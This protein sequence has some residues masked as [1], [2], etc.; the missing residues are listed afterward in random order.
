M[1]DIYAELKEELSTLKPDISDFETNDATF[2]LLSLCKLASQII[3]EADINKKR[4]TSFQE[5][6]RYRI[7]KSVKF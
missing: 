1:I 4:T 6:T 5:K 2:N 3:E 7:E